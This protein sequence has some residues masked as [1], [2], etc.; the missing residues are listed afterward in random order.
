MTI[1]KNNI[2]RA[3]E[4]FENG[5]RP[6]RFTEARSWYIVGKND[7]LYPLKYIYALAINK[8]PS[9]FN[10]SEPISVLSNLDI[11]LLHQPKDSNADFYVKVTQSIKNPRGRASRLEKAHRKPK[12]KLS[13]VVIYERNPDVVAEVLCRANGYCEDCGSEAPFMRKKDGTPYL[14]VHHKTLIAEGGE[15]TVENAEALCPNCHRKKHFG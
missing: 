14:E 4:R 9:S 13:K 1:T 10:T 12:S 7:Y 11:E 15:D 5:E 6:F 8:T 3:I 2:K